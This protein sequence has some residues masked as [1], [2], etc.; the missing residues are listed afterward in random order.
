MKTTEKTE[1]F[2]TELSSPLGQLTLASDGVFLVGLWFAGQKHF[3]GA[4]P[5]PFQKK[6]SLPVFQ[7]AEQWLN[8][9]FSGRRPEPESIPILLSGTIFQRTV[10]SSLA[11][12]PYGETITYGELGRCVA[13]KLGRERTSARAIGGAVGR[14]PVSIILPCHRVVGS[15][16]CMTGFAAGLEKK[17]FLLSL[18]KMG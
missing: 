4:F 3:G 11:G 5:Q 1:Y 16:G 14:N 8:D 18:E 7:M 9:Y 13:E 12:I 6:D 17:H 2:S 15:G 10:W